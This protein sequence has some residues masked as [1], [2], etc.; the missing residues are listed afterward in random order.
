MRRKLDQGKGSRQQKIRRALKFAAWGLLSLATAVTMIA[1]FYP[2][3]QWWSDVIR[4]DV[5]SVATFWLILISTLTFLNAGWL[6]ESVCTHMCPYSRFQSV[7]FDN[8]TRT[9]RYDTDRGEPR[10]KNNPENKAAGD[11]IDCGLCVQVCPTNIDIRDGLQ[12]ACIDC[13]ACIDA[14]D[15]VMLQTGRATGLI[16]Y[17]PEQ[18]LS[19]LQRWRLWGYGALA[20]SAFV[21]VL[22]NTLLQPPLI[23]SLERDRLALYQL[24]PDDT[25]INRYTLK[26]HNRS[27]ED[28]QLTVYDQQD[29]VLQTT[30]S[31]GQRAAHSLDI[32]RTTETPS[33]A[34]ELR[35]EDQRSGYHKN[36]PAR[37]TNPR[38]RTANLAANH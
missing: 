23:A 24:T 35:I 34:L 1:Y 19:P 22:A 10:G 18:Q 36:L 3:A 26:L 16:T 7:M 37:F 25:L 9:V 38:V 6:R 27:H 31:A 4:G 2:L 29:A 21:V 33:Q 11:C 28:M 15:K 14:C 12:I 17:Q 13:G 32:E 20:I 5:S 30:L 8:Q